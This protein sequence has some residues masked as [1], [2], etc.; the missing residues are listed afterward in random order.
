MI[1]PTPCPA[2]GGSLEH[3]IHLHDGDVYW[4]TFFANVVLVTN[5]QG[6]TAA[7]IDFTEDRS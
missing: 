5:E 6:A 1:K 3:A 4:S 2:C 7:L